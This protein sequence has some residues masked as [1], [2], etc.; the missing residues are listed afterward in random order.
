MIRILSLSVLALVAFA[1]PAQA[2]FIIDNF[3]VTDDVNVGG[4]SVIHNH[5]RGAISAEATS[6]GTAVGSAIDGFGYIVTGASLGDTFTLAYTWP[7]VFG[8]NI[9]SVFVL[10]FI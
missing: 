2:D 10:M 9:S 5:P 8:G 7:G 4:S 3:K 1:A 6:T